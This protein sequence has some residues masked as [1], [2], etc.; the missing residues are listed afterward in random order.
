[1]SSLAPT[2]K[3]VV[4]RGSG[5][6]DKV[7]CVAA[8]LKICVPAAQAGTKPSTECCGKL[9]KQKSCLCGYIKDPKYR[10][11]VSSGGARKVLAACGVPYPTC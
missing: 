1:M 8:E 2:T 5:E 4:V 10:Q 7:A 9:K 6:E 11:Y 3:A